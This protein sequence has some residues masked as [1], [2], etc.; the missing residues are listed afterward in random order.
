MCIRWNLFRC[1][2]ILTGKSNNYQSWLWLILTG[3]FLNS[4]DTICWNRYR[5][6][7]WL[8]SVSADCIQW[9]NLSISVIISSSNCWIYLSKSVTIKTDFIEYTRS[10]KICQKKVKLKRLSFLTDFV[11]SCVSHEICIKIYRFWQVYP[12]MT[13][14]EYDW[15]R[16]IYSLDKICWNRYQ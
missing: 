3:F 8:I 10:Y 6:R 11:I 2:Q 12:T 4:L 1:L 13:W 16:Q 15:Y 14:A 7:F 9:I 5:M